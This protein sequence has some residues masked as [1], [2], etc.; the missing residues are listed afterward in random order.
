[1]AALI[2]LH[3]TDQFKRV[4]EQTQIAITEWLLSYYYRKFLL[5]I[6]R[7]DQHRRI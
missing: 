2:L 3:L 1:M 7:A 5:R 6:W 4:R